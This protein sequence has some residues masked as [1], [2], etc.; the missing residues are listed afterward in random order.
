MTTARY[1]WNESF[2]KRL[3]QVGKDRMSSDA[4]DVCE[5]ALNRIDDLETELKKERQCGWGGDYGRCILNKE[6]DGG[7]DLGIR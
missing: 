6:H 5:D 4:W 3:R 1:S 7:H 2:R